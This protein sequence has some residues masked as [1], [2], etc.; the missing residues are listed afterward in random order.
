VALSVIVVAALFGAFETT[1]LFE[2]T[3]RGGDR[4][5]LT[6]FFMRCCEPA[7]AEAV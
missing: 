2:K 5:L 7:M 3:T 6:R 4:H 1:A